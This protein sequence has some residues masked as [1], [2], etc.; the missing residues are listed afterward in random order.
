MKREWQPMKCLA[1]TPNRTVVAIKVKDQFKLATVIGNLDGDEHWKFQLHH[2]G[3]KIYHH[4]SAPWREAQ[5][6][7]MQ[8]H[9]CLRPKLNPIKS[10][11][12]S[13]LK[14]GQVTLTMSVG[15]WDALLQANYEMG[16]VLLELDWDENPVS[17][18]QLPLENT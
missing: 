18:Y 13:I 6:I 4:R 3:W 2:P 17:A 1:G 9:D 12:P 10:D 11:L 7:I 16:G 8:T 14:P 5:F 15:Q